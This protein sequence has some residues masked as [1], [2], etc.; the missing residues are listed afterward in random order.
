MKFLDK[1]VI[2]SEVELECGC[3]LSHKYY[4]VS[5]VKQNT[6]REEIKYKLDFDIEKDTLVKFFPNTKTLDKLEQQIDVKPCYLHLNIFLSSI[7]S[8][9][10]KYYKEIPSSI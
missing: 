7:I 9:V 4:I 5:G 6:A 3:L 10:K 8:G 2:T 1:D